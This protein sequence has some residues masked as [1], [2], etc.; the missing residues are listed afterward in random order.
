M[1][2][3]MQLYIPELLK[4][5]VSSPPKNFAYSFENS[6]TVN[7]CNHHSFT[8]QNL[9]GICKSKS[10]RHH[11][12]ILP[13][14]LLL[15]SRWYGLPLVLC[16]LIY[17]FKHHQCNMGHC[18]LT[19]IPLCTSKPTWVTGNT[20]CCSVFSCGRKMFAGSER[21]HSSSSACKQFFRSWACACQ[22]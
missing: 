2:K 4:A 22:I 21:G 8:H 15:L 11:F 14:P 18:S 10:Q 5:G 3:A 20:I 7:I 1:F 17:L 6:F 13:V 19:L 16:Y 12:I 9:V